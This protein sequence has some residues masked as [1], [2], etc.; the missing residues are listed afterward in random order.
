MAV[1][2]IKL[3]EVQILC[4]GAKKSWKGGGGLFGGGATGKE[5]EVEAQE[6]CVAHQA[7]KS[8]CREGGIGWEL[9]AA[10]FCTRKRPRRKGAEKEENSR[11]REK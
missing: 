9:K 6:V 1:R 8:V 3:K 5:R 7:E 10:L 2:G 11:P 4:V